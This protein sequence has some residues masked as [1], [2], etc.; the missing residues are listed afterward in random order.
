MQLPEIKM[1]PKRAR[2]D[3]IGEKLLRNTGKVHDRHR[4]ITILDNLIQGH[5]NF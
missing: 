2:I 5:T 1:F 3:I 4:S